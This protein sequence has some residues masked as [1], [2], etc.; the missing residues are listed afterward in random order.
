M[1]ENFRVVAL[2]LP[3]PPF[4]GKPLDPPLRSRFQARLVPPVDAATQFEA[5]CAA[6]PSVPRRTLQKLVTFSESMKAIEAASSSVGGAAS[7]CPFP[8]FLV[9]AIARGLQSFATA[10]TTTATT[11]AAAGTGTVASLEEVDFDSH[12]GALLGRSY[13]FLLPAVA[14][15]MPLPH[16]KA[17]DG[18]MQKL[19]IVQPS[20]SGMSRNGSSSSSRSSCSTGGQHQPAPHGHVTNVADSLVEADVGR[21]AGGVSGGAGGFGLARGGH[22]F[23]D[24]TLTDG[25]AGNALH[26]LAAPGGR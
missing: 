22:S 13:P 19:G 21:L 18:L 11:G 20:P 2:G 12:L 25:V 15:R 14:A 16:Q 10:T 26:R 8:E 5:A 9:P 3:V 7:A 24:V 1:H 6:A 4:A 23:V 17:V